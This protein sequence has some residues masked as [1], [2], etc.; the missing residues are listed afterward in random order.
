MPTN[1]PTKSFWETP[2]GHLVVS[3]AVT[4]VLAAVT[5]FVNSPA[6]ASVLGGGVTVTVGKYLVDVLRQ[7][8][9]TL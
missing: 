4:G 3:A 8:A 9:G 5:A 2:L 7:Y 1:T 6:A